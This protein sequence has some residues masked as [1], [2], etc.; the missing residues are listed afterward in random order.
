MFVNFGPEEGDVLPTKVNQF[1]FKTLHN[2]L[3]TC[4]FPKVCAYMF[5]VKS[6]QIY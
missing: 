1:P 3:N 2:F 6:R 5:K 4:G